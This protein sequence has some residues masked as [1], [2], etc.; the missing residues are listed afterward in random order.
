MGPFNFMHFCLIRDRE[1]RD[2]A[3]TADGDLTGRRVVMTREE[4]LAKSKALRA[5]D[6]T[7]GHE[8]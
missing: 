2:K 3:L 4:F 5:I 6:N 7:K 1:S 8:G